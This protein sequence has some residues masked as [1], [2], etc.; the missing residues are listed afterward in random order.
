MF[1]GVTLLAVNIHNGGCHPSHLLA[2]IMLNGIVWL[3][4]RSPS[5]RLITSHGAPYDAVV[6]IMAMA[7]TISHI[8]YGA[9]LV[10]ALAEQQWPGHRR[11]AVI[12]RHT[13]ARVV[14]AVLREKDVEGHIVN[15]PQH[16]SIAGC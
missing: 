14:L 1:I 13:I 2:I 3:T 7:I 11:R 8:R 10:L 9:S 5:S 15:G 4:A 12:T 16:T 6:I